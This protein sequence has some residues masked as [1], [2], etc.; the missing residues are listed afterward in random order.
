MAKEKGGSGG[1]NQWGK[2]LKNPELFGKGDRNTIEQ[3]K[4]K[5]QKTLEK[6]MKEILEKGPKDK[7]K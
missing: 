4:N 5:E 1:G 6:S 2:M 7:E 3:L